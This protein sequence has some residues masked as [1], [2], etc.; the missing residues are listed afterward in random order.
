MEGREHIEVVPVAVGAAEVDPAVGVGLKELVEAV[1]ESDGHAVRQPRARSKT[2]LLPGNANGVLLSRCD[3]RG[4]STHA[5]R[6]ASDK[7]V[8]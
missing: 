5:A 4:V 6:G 7:A 3:S 2:D 8:N 1:L